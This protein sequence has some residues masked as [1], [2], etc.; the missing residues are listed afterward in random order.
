MPKPARLASIV[1]MLLLSGSAA[2]AGRLEALV[3]G[4]GRIRLMTGDGKRIGTIEAGLFEKGWRIG[5]RVGI[6]GRQPKDIGTKR[7]RLPI[8]PIL[9]ASC[10]D[11][12]SR[13]PCRSRHGSIHPSK[14]G[15]PSERS[16]DT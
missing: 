9:D 5:R 10:G 8:V 6:K 15:V 2:G 1:C 7:F 14:P 13:R 3:G 4:D 12:R 16:G 11:H